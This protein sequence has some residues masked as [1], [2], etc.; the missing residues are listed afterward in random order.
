[1]NP[2]KPVSLDASIA[3]SVAAAFDEAAAR[4]TA[5]EPAPEPTPAPTEAAP[6]E[7]ETTQ[8]REAR[9][10]DEQ[11]RFARRSTDIK[12][13]PEVKTKAP[14]EA[15]ATAGGGTSP[16]PGETPPAEPVS[17]P[18]AVKAPQSW[19]PAAR[20]E[21][22][23]VPPSVQA[24]VMRREKETAQVLQ[25]AAEARKFHSTFR[26]QLAPYAHMFGPDAVQG[27]AVMARDIH[28]LTN[29]RGPQQAAMVAQM[30]RALNVDIEALDHALS[31]EAPRTQ[32]APPPVDVE[33]LVEKKLQSYAQQAA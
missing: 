14:P 13:P 7:P 31:G 8:E 11:G 12:K 33:Q 18:E 29:A 15:P 16:P 21:W 1:M 5:P 24:E 25:E 9:V 23:K 30:I 3:D 26:E 4:D 28:A 32:Q 2:E 10:R 20:E 22:A 6:V 17:T 19:K 27:V